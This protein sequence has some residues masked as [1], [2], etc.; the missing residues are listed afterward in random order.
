MES[1][2]SLGRFKLSALRDKFRKPAERGLRDRAEA[3]ASYTIVT[4]SI[5]IIPN[6][7][8]SLSTVFRRLIH[9]LCGQLRAQGVGCQRT[10]TRVVEGSATGTNPAARK[11]PRVP[12]EAKIGGT[13]AELGL[14][15]NASTRGAPASRA[16]A[17]AARIMSTE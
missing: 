10:R 9:R 1:D 3:S 5:H 14:R 13:S 11:A 8:T 7:P 6:F 16:K 15:G 17:Q 12:W 2:K 4:L